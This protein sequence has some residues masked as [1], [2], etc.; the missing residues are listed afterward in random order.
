MDLVGNTPKITGRR[1]RRLP[2]ADI[3]II[4]FEI[5]VAFWIAA[6]SARKFRKESV[7]VITATF[8]VFA[9]PTAR[10]ILV[11]VGTELPKHLVCRRPVACEHY[12]IGVGRRTNVRSQDENK[13]PCTK[14]C[15]EFP[16]VQKSFQQIFTRLQLPASSAI[17]RENIFLPCSINNAENDRRAGSFWF[18]PSMRLKSILCD[19]A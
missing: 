18:S 10:I 12:V 15:A 6:G 5:T 13:K 14:N 1:R 4:N 11:R 16:A 7:D 9:L 17:R 19:I 3:L 8:P 2:R